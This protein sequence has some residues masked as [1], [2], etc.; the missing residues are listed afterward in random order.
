MDY[1]FLIHYPIGPLSL[2]GR[3][4]TREEEQPQ[5]GVDMGDPL[6]VGCNSTLSGVLLWVLSLTIRL[7]GLF[8]G[9][10]GL[11]SLLVQGPLL[12]SFLMA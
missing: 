7:H 10:S 3:G 4:F 6:P 11:S 9:V 5:T 8:P 12:S 2:D 1:Q